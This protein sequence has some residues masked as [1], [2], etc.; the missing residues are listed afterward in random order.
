MD[1]SVW[2][3]ARPA[4]HCEDP[5]LRYSQLIVEAREVDRL[6][7]RA[8]WTSEQH[9]AD[10]GYLGSQLTLLAAVAAVTD[11]LRLTTSVVVVPF[12]RIRQLC[13]AALVVQLV[14]NGRLELGVGAGGYL[15]EFELFDVDFATRGA[16]T[17]RT[18]RELRDALE[19]WEL[20]DGAGGEPVPLRPRPA[21]RVPV[22]VGGLS[23]VAV[24]RAARLADGLVSY[25]FDR[26]ES[27]LPVLY[28]TTIAPALERYG[29]S[30]SDFHLATALPLW[31]SDDP[32]RDWCTFYARAYNYQQRRYREWAGDYDEGGMRREVD[33]RSRLL[34][35]TPERVAA[36]L[37]ELRHAVPWDELAFWYRLPGVPHER[38]LEHLETVARRVW[39]PLERAFRGWDRAHQKDAP[40]LVPLTAEPSFV[41]GIEHW[42]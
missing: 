39:P 5:R 35:D 25:D 7:Y 40:R 16:I 15:R 27:S 26:P 32:E 41:D 9:G 34:V 2:T 33:G 18:V 8:F 31:A 20:R 6:D 21:V 14:S 30:P 22:L 24:E 17:E 3:D 28:R 38:A 11:R 12:W 36:R 10:D 19:H 29:R 13:E 1:L 42:R 4:P 23:R 37:I